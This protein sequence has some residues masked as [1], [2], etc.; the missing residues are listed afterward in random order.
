MIDTV[1]FDLDNTLLDFSKAERIALKAALERMGLQPGNEMLD[2]Y[3]VLNGE[4]WKLLELGKLTREEVKE[5]RFELLFQEYGLNCSA[6]E[7]T[8]IY[9]KLLEIGHYFVE[10]TPELL[11]ELFSKYRMYIVTNGTASVQKCRMKSAEIE[12]YFSGVFI[13]EE[14]GFD[15]PTREYF[16]RCFAKIQGFQKEN[17]VIIGDSLTSDIR[18]GK[19]T[20]IRTIWFNPKHIQNNTDIQPDHEIECLNEIPELLRKM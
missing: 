9:E 11:E 1:L 3:S 17:A 20:G 6:K 13:S 4:Q 18:G 15:K 7:A 12:K 14:I 5:R 10:G 19:N 8:E 2:R 16:D